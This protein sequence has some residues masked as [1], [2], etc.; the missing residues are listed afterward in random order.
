MARLQLKLAFVALAAS[1]AL[2]LP[3]GAKVL[4]FKIIKA[5]HSSLKEVL[6]KDA[7]RLGRSAATYGSAAIGSGTVTN[8]LDSYVAPVIIGS[9][10]FSVRTLC[11]VHDA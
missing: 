10:T 4:T 5:G 8:E 9:Q 3:A 6:A 1:A 7:V 11:N 2:A